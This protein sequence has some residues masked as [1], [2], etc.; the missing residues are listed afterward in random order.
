MS[1]QSPKHTSF[2]ATVADFPSTILDE[3]SGGLNTI[4]KFNTDR[5][6]GYKSRSV[7]GRLSYDYKTKYLLDVSFRYDGAQYFA[8]KWGFFPSISAGWIVTREDFMEGISNTLTEF[9]IKGSWGRLGDLSAA[10]SLY[11]DSGLYYHQS[12]YKYPGQVLAFGDK[13]IFNP[14]ETVEANPNFTWATSTMINGGF[15]TRFWDKKLTISAEYFVRDRD[16]LPAKRNNDNA[17]VLAT[18]YNLNSDRTIGFDVSL[19]HENTIG[20]FKYSING[21]IS[22]ARTKNIYNEDNGQWTN[23]YSKWKFDADGRWNN[24]R[25]GH[26]VIGRY[27]NQEE[28]YGAPIHLK[29]S[30][31]NQTILPG[32]LKYE[33]YNGDGYINANDQKPI[34]RGVYPE[35]IFG[36]FFN[37]EWNNFDFSMFWQ[38]AAL[39]QFNLGIFDSHAFREGDLETNAWS[40]FEDR[41]RKADY[42]NPNSVWISGKYPAIRDFFSAGDINNKSDYPSQ[43]YNEDGKYI[44][45]KN[46][47]LG[48]SIPKRVAEK[49]K[50]TSLRIYANAT[51]VFT[52]STNKFIDPEQRNGGFNL[53]SYPQIRSF[54]YGIN[55][56]F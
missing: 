50:T 24:I 25:W 42:T 6:R 41:W 46:I 1:L 33:D 52:F 51:N 30:N 20:D 3:F 15:D 7:I 47:E 29:S 31:L 40:Y 56:K 8:N 11:T 14:Q 5:L 37:A 27:Q 53:A 21:N 54:N 38:G 9:K 45:L 35:L 12:G 32:D 16:G 39:S 48:Y 36:G 26:E 22:W 17:G 10:R 55:L 44:R 13:T 4:N 43:F 34:G 2:S 18:F 23:G 19:G 28:I 49:L